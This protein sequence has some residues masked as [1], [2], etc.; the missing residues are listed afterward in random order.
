MSVSRPLDWN[1]VHFGLSSRV[2][3]PLAFKETAA[4]A[5]WPRK[6]SKVYVIRQLQYNTTP[7]HACVF[8][9]I[10]CTAYEIDFTKITV[11]QTKFTHGL[12]RTQTSFFM[13]SFLR[14]SMP[15]GYQ[16]DIRN[17]SLFKNSMDSFNQ[18]FTYANQAKNLKLI[19][20][21]TERFWRFCYEIQQIAFFQ[22]TALSLCWT[23]HYDYGT[24]GTQL[25]A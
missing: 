23:E 6:K 19:A 8:C 5:K 21:R 13:D 18:K 14:Y 12:T 25:T 16:R 7:L 3:L 24:E 1:L 20:A 10:V 2:F 15:E 9:N 11:M 17:I 4:D 22:L